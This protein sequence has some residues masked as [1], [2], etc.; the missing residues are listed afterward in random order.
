MVDPEIDQGPEAHD[1]DAGEGPVGA[2]EVAD[3]AGVQAGPVAKPAMPAAA[4]VRTAA[5]APVGANQNAVSAM[6]RKT[7]PTARREVRMNETTW[8]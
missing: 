2:Q 8:S 1:G 7:M 6:A 3:R 5:P 4:P